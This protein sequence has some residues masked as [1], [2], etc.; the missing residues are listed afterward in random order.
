[1]C[2]CVCM[3]VCVSVCAH[4]H[5]RTSVSVCVLVQGRVRV[6]ACVCVCVC[7][8]VCVFVCVCVCVQPPGCR[9]AT[10][11]RLLREEN[12]GVHRDTCALQGPPSHVQTTSGPLVENHVGGMA[13]IAT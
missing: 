10:A 12:S 8:R 9:T 2:V 7:V 3:C 1:M 13:S 4:A 5:A 6:C 11:A